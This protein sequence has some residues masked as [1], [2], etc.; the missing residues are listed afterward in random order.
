MLFLI[1]LL[2]FLNSADG[3]KQPYNQ[4]NKL[5]INYRKPVNNNNNITLPYPKTT[6]I[7]IYYPHENNTN[8]N[9]NFLNNYKKLLEED[10]A[11][12]PDD[13]EKSWQYKKM[14]YNYHI[15]AL[16]GLVGALFIGN[17]FCK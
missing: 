1:G 8:I 5:I 13:T 11:D 7:F 12:E 16:L 3:F 10:E 17:I 2:F 15:G 9:N 6:G 14:Q 4:L